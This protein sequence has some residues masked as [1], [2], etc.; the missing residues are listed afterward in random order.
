MRC[1]KKFSKKIFWKSSILASNKSFETEN[2]FIHRW[3]LNTFQ[4]IFFD[5]P[6]DGAFN[7]NIVISKKFS[8]YKYF[9]LNKIVSII[10]N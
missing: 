6:L 8:K 10:E 9:L 5:S 4:K 1:Q 2:K 7:F 3:R